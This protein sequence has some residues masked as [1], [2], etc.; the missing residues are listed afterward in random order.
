MNKSLLNICGSAVAYACVLGATGAAADSHNGFTTVETASCSD[1]AF[2]AEVTQEFPGV[3]SACRGVV[4]DANGKFYARIAARVDYVRRDRLRGNVVAATLALLD[5]E[6]EDLRKISTRPARNFRFMV[7]GQEYGSEA[8]GRGTTL[9]VYLPADRWEL[10]WSPAIATPLD[11][12][13]LIEDMESVLVTSTLEADDSFAFDSAELSAAGKAS[14]DAL[15]EATQGHVTAITI[16][17]YTD[18]IGDETYN[19]GLSERRADAAKAYLVEKGVPE[20]RITSDGRGESNPVVT[21]ENLGGNAL[22]K[23]L[24]PNRRVDIAMLIPAVADVATV[25]V[26]K[27]YRNP[28]GEEVVV[29]EQLSLAQ[30]TEFNAVKN[31]FLT[32]CEAEI[33]RYC[34]GVE[35]GGGRII[36]CLAAGINSS[37][38]YSEQ[39]SASITSVTDAMMNRRARLNAVGQSCSAEL[40]ACDSVRVTVQDKLACIADNPMSQACSSAMSSLTSAAF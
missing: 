36:G 40:A 33:D 13:V 8:L 5:A 37:E 24:A 38:P 31:D 3:M 35:V 15:L 19:L 22:I 34:S 30:F 12:K 39:C 21:C 29:S 27:T 7:D 20:R 32:S 14:L 4:R 25:D 1:I 18:I 6:G 17:G 9:S 16:H 10:A 11:T 26:T 2:T 28:L 23:C